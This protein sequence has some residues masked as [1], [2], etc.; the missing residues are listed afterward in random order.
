MPQTPHLLNGLNN[1]LTYIKYPNRTAPGT[2]DTLR[3]RQPV[4]SFPQTL[5]RTSSPVLPPLALSS[6]SY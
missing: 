1:E 6:H 5:A 2:K 4:L 3:N